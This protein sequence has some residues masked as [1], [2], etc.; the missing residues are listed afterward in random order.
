MKKHIACFVSIVV[1]TVIFCLLAA[2]GEII[3]V[4]RKV[5]PPA[6]VP[7]EEWLDGFKR[8]ALIIVA[9]AGISSLT[10]YILGQ[11]VFKI[12]NWPKSGKRWVWL[13]LFIVPIVAIIFGIYFPIVGFQI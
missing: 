3:I 7:A 5:I 10:W 12:D 11:W 4:S 13:L 1:I 9:V 2:Y 8:W 6:D